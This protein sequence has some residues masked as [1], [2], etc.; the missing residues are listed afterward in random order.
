MNMYIFS[1]V[2]HGIYI[3]VKKCPVQL[4]TDYKNYLIFIEEPVYSMLTY[5]LVLPAY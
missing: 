3:Y 1:E 2:K 4:V 5:F